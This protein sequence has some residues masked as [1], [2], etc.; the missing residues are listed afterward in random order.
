MDMGS[1]AAVGGV[2]FDNLA[3]LFNSMGLGS[4]LPSG[5]IT[6]VIGLSGGSGLAVF[7]FLGMFLD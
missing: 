2:L 7:V 3:Q 1:L 4:I 6:S 5:G